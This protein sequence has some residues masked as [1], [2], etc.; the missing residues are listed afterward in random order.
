ML[1][2]PALVYE[3]FVVEVA[4]FHTAPP[5]Q[6]WEDDYPA[7]L[8]TLVVRKGGDA[9]RLIL[10]LV[11]LLPKGTIA[12][13]ATKTRWADPS[14]QGRLWFVR[15]RVTI[16]AA[17]ELRALVAVGGVVDLRTLGVAA[18]NDLSPMA[19]GSTIEEPPWPCAAFQHQR[20][21]LQATWQGQV[22]VHY[23]LPVEHPLRADP[24]EREAILAELSEW[25]FF[26]AE[27]HQ[28]LLG[29]FVVLAPNPRYE[30]LEIRRLTNATAQ[31]RESLALC[32]VP[33]AGDSLE[34]LSVRVRS[35]RPS[36]E[37]V[38]RAL[39]VQEPLLR[40]DFDHPMDRVGIEVTDLSR[41]VLEVQDPF[42][43]LAGGF[44]VRTSFEDGSAIPSADPLGAFDPWSL[45]GSRRLPAG[46][47]RREARQASAAFVLF[48]GDEQ[49][50]RAARARLLAAA[51][52][53]LLLAVDVLSGA[54]LEVLRAWARERRRSLFALVRDSRGLEGAPIEDGPRWGF[55]VEVRVASKD[56]LPEGP[57]VV[58]EQKTWAFTGCVARLGTR[59]TSLHELP[60][61]NDLRGELLRAWH[62]AVPVASVPALDDV[63]RPFHA[64]L[65]HMLLEGAS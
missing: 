19:V 18:W 3:P 16:A 29:A 12:P 10:G 50:W 64:S 62:A 65:V 11:E 46:E 5:K 13:T 52:P 48:D 22:R 21:P 4:A 44:S 17:L 41:G 33:R 35:V 23:L 51:G 25:L 53:Y 7:A 60:Q 24:V 26:R 59:G 37:F 30:E 61:L 40:V 49:R 36:G 43:F 45:P 54:D 27:E 28:E 39:P 55:S 57:F 63:A 20:H 31:A 15:E 6:L 34:G 32:F 58:S 9:A 38:S 2:E 8:V 1:N 56:A 42:I 47:G 14:P